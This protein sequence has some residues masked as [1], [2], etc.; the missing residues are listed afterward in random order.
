MNLS[1]TGQWWRFNLFGICVLLTLTPGFICRAQTQLD[2]QTVEAVFQAIEDNDT[3]GLQVIYARNTNC[4]A[5]DYYG[6]YNSRHYPLLQAAADGRT[7]I[8]AL[9]LRHGASPNVAGDTRNSGN[10]QVTP[11]EVAAQHSHL[12]ICEILLRAG[13]NPNHH[14]FSG[15]TAL[16][17]AFGTFHIPRARNS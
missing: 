12:E 17:N 7:A 14:S 1:R 15:E 9:L 6:V 3:N 13:A 8:V 5:D 10:S 4:V 11:L 16:H 2:H